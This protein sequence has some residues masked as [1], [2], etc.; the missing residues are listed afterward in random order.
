MVK[1][2]KIVAAGAVGTR[3]AGERMLQPKQDFGMVLVTNVAGAKAD[4]AF[5]AL[6]EQLSRTYGAKK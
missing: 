6:A 3:K 4:H 2:G 1:D 5:H